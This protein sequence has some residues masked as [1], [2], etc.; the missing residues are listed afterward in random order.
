[1][2]ADDDS[3]KTRLTPL[4]ELYDVIW[5]WARTKYDSAIATRRIEAVDP[6]SR[7]FIVGEA[8]AE[9]QVRLTGVNWFNA[10]GTL[11]AAGKYLDTILRCLGYTVHPPT[12]VCLS[13]GSVWP[14]EDELTTV[15][16]TDIFP[17]YPPDGELTSAMV[18]DAL[19]QGFLIREFEIL[20]P[21]VVLL[22]GKHSYTAFYTHLLRTATVGKISKEFELLSPSTELREY[23]GALVVPFLHPS[24]Q[25]GTFSHWYKNSRPSL[26]AQPQIQAIAGALKRQV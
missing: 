26:C 17:C 9:D 2:P 20:R 25:S 22:L 19:K 13:H 10:Q 3:R 18:A 14:K 6:D 12:S 16:T 21:K 8:H 4:A 7:L 23:R 1:M 11:G 5:D 15:Y 24:P